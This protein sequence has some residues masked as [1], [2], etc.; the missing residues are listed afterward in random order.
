[1]NIQ[2]CCAS[3][4][5][6]IVCAVAFTGLVS[7]CGDGTE[8]SGS[9]VTGA[10]ETRTTGAETTQTSGSSSGSDTQSTSS[11]G[12]QTD[13]ETQTTTAPTDTETTTDDPTTGSSTTLKFDVGSEVDFGQD[14]CQA[15]CG[16]TD[17]SYVW[18]ANSAEH[19]VSKLNTR[20]LEEEGRYY[21][22][23]DQ[24]GSP[25]RT[26]VS[27]DGR[28]VVVANRFGGLTKIWAREEFCDDRNE[29]GVI[30]TST[31]KDDVLPFA[32][33]ECIAWFTEFPDMTVQR[34][35][36]WTSGVYNEETCEY[37]NQ[38]I[39]TLTGALGDMPGR[40]GASGIYVHRISGD[41]GETNAAT[42]IPE[43]D[44]SCLFGNSS[45][46]GAYGA[47]VDPDNNMWFYVF[48]QGKIVRVAYD[49]LEYEV[50]SGGSYGITVDT[51]GRVWD[52]SPRR[53]D[54]ETK[55]WANAIGSLPGSGGS[56]VAQD[57]QG[58]IWSATQGGIGWLDMETMEVGDI[59][60]LPDPQIYRGISVDVD[61]YV[62][63][64]PLS[65]TK[66]YRVDPDSYEYDFY[67]GL[68]SP[69]TYSDMSGGQINN[70]T[71]NDP[72]G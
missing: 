68:N 22:R 13:G 72:N 1:M 67:E 42:H 54:Y 43:S 47:A 25:S 29:N 51:N 49:T 45:G 56:G 40:C 11:G 60:P 62:W 27:V 23:A 7:G 31:G 44:V 66:A 57:L 33:D 30:D 28:A 6:N 37:D 35:V 36:A 59:V 17:W 9:D 53:F 38:E 20:T 50:F 12:S 71:C 41:T 63:A 5:K 61:G 14:D 24:S 69:Y 65:G 18:L 19:T 70:V 8:V 58:R 16:N 48:G 26:S 39:W 46:F 55:Q 10:S 64:V 21:T 3:T 52:D 32:E 15:K 4:V 2:F 34:P